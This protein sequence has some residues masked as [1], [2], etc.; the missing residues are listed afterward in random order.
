MLISNLQNLGINYREWLVYK[1]LADLDLCRSQVP[2]YLPVAPK[3]FEV[4]QGCLIFSPIYTHFNTLKK[5][6]L[7]KHCG[8]R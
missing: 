3:K 5:K 2:L 7:G 8:K 4:L 6:A 1:D